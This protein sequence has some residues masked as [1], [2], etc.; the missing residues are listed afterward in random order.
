M[1]DTS[2]CPG[3][4]KIAARAAIRHQ[5]R[6]LASIRAGSL[7]IRPQKRRHHL[8]VIHVSPH[9]S[10]RAAT[11]ARPARFSDG[12]TLAYTSL[13]RR[14]ACPMVARRTTDASFVNDRHTYQFTLLAD[15][16]VLV[17]GGMD[18]TLEEVLTSTEI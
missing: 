8:L 17:A 3:Q 12:S 6:H 15:G 18:W 11:R 1:I 5:I 14:S 10:T 4:A 13:M 16:R 9:A 7:R 2:R